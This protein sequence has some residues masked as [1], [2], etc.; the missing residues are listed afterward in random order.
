[1]RDNYLL[2]TQDDGAAAYLMPEVTETDRALWHLP[3]ST[4]QSF[5][6]LIDQTIRT[7]H[8]NMCLTANN[9]GLITLRKCRQNTWLIDHVNHQI[10][11]TNLLLCLT[12]AK[13]A[14]LLQPCNKL[15]T[16]LQTWK[17]EYVNVNPELKEDIPE[18]TIE[19]RK[20]EL[21]IIYRKFIIGVG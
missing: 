1:M 2:T 3:A 18:L 13:T 20:L 14:L 9:T 4:H 11:E 8:T 19:V 15:L 6:Y 17:I 7:N 10:I 16:E 21:V 12:A 5:E